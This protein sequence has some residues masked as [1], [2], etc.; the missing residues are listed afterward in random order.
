MKLPVL[1][2]VDVSLSA[3]GREVVVVP[4]IPFAQVLF[5]GKTFTASGSFVIC[6]FDEVASFERS[7][8]T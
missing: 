5:G 2:K 3:L 4:R 6:T 8:F 7:N 1:L